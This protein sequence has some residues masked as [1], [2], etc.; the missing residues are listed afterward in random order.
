MD[1]RV[2]K[3]KEISALVEDLA[4]LRIHIFKEFPYLYE[5]NKAFEY[6]YLNK[7]VESDCSFLKNHL[8][9]LVLKSIQSFIL[10]KVYY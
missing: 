1:F 4:E 8:S 10:E 6:E 9:K 7:Y 5:G 3:G 2:Y